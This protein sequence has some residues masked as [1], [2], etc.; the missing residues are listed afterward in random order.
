MIMNAAGIGL[1]YILIF[2]IYYFLYRVVKIIAQDLDLLKRPGFLP[3]KNNTADYK[4]QA[5]L[6]V[7]ESE[8]AGFRQRD[9]VIRDVLSI[10]RSQQNDIII[11]EAIVS[12]EHA[13]ITYYKERYWLTDLHSTNKTY[14]NGKA[15]QEEVVL[16]NG[17]LIRIGSVTF[18]FEG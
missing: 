13:N 16:N 11:P 2:F 5:R 17:D 10:G 9:A 8:L 3:G 4:T 1:Q 12:A 15:V 6:T 14:L 7:V 18:K